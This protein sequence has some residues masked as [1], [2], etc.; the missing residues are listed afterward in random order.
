MAFGVKVSANV[1]SLRPAA[2]LSFGGPSNAPCA[3]L[4]P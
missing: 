2:E 1:P 3:G 4:T